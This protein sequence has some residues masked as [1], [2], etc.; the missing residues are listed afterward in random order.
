MGLFTPD[1]N[2]KIHKVG[3]LEVIYAKNLIHVETNLKNQVELIEFCDEKY[4][5]GFKICGFSKD[6]SNRVFIILD[7]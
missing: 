7:K 1:N 5:E 6:E 4:S 3:A 2:E